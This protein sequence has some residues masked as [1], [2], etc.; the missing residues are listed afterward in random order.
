MILGAAWNALTSGWGEAGPAVAQISSVSTLGYRVAQTPSFSIEMGGV[1]TPEGGFVPNTG[2]IDVTNIGNLTGADSKRMVMAST[3][4]LDWPA[5]LAP[6][7][8]NYIMNFFSNFRFWQPGTTSVG[9]NWLISAFA[10]FRDGDIA[11]TGR[12]QNPNGIYRVAESLPDAY[13][14]YTDRWLTFIYAEAETDTVFANWNSGGTTGTYYGR[15]ALW[16]TET[17]TLL[18]LQDIAFTPTGGFIDYLEYGN[19]ASTIGTD[20]S[21][22]GNNNV[23]FDVAATNQYQFEPW[24][25]TNIWASYGQTFDPAAPPD[26]S[27]FTTRPSEVMGD[28]EAWFNIQFTEVNAQYAVVDQG[29]SRYSPPV[30]NVALGFFNGNAEIGYSTA[31]VPYDRNI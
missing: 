13:T 25:L 27:V 11:V 4:R 10:Q 12:M 31:D 16:D 21:D 15:S 30:S 19:G 1:S 14:N 17:R 7:A 29:F 18:D 5:N 20:R 3:F 8:G 24:R 2:T 23:G 22:A 6:P 26:T 9:E 28:V